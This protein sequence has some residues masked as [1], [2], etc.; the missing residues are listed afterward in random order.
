[1]KRAGLPVAIRAGALVGL[2]AITVAGCTSSAKKGAGST[3]SA[4]STNKGGGSTANAAAG[5]TVPTGAQFCKG[6]KIVFFPGGTAG[7]GFETVV[8]NGAKAAAAALGPDVTYEWSDWDPNKMISQFQQAVA[9]K[10]DGIAIMGHPG[11]SAFDPL[12]DQAESQGIAVTVMNTE[13]P[14]AEA[15]YAAQG[16]GYAGATLYD[17]GAAL[18]NEAIKRDNLAKGSRVFVWG[19]ASQPGRGERTK[20]IVDALNKA[21]MTV[22]YLEIS[23]AA[24]S[25]P[26]AGVPIFTGYVS[27]HPDVKAMFIDHGNLTSAIPTFMKAANLKPGSV[28]MAGFDMSAATVKGI[29]DGYV[30]LVIDQQ[31]WLQGYLGIEQLCLA[32]EYGFSGLR[33]DTGGGF[34]DKSNIAMIAPLVNKQIR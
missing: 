25:D 31:E 5:G 11:D 1:M 26:S 33:V 22:D 15:K 27:K 28:Y 7:G 17:A 14:T 13:L 6:M 20:G 18:A 4:A 21:G 30:N 23:D 24:N 2:V 9:T 10:P 32:H 12:I 3:N 16:M 8:Y 29:Q 34:V 19:L